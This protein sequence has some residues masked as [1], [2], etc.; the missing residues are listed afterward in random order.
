MWRFWETKVN[1]PKLVQRVIKLAK[2]KGFRAGSIQIELQITHSLTK[3][4]VD[5]ETHLAPALVPTFCH[6]M[7][8]TLQNDYCVVATFPG[9]QTPV[10]PLKE[11]YLHPSSSTI[12]VKVALHKGSLLCEKVD[13]IVN[14]ANEDLKHCG[15]LAKLVADADGP[16]IKRESLQHVQE[17]GKL[18]PGDAVCLSAGNLPLDLAGQGKGM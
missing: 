18:K 9:R 5:V 14:P 2:K 3:K 17:N 16:A 1:P 8:A 15:G 7:Q 11:V 4:Q 13:V 10:T 12:K 6:Q